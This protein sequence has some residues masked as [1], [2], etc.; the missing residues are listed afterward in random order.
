V[1]REPRWAVAHKYPAQE[2]LTTVLN[3][4]VQ[5]GRTGKLT[6]V[7]KLAPV[8]VGGTTVSNATLHNLFE[9]RRKGV[10]V[11]DTVIVRR[12]GDVIPEVVG[13]CRAR[14]GYVPNFRMPRSCPVCGSRGARA[15]AADHRCT[16]RPVLRRAAQAGHPA[17]CRRR[18]MEVEGLGDKLVDQ[19]VDGGLIRT[20]PELYRLGWPSWRRWTAWPR[21][22]RPTWLAGA[23][24]EQAD[25]AAALPVTRWASAMSARPRPRTW[26]ALRQP[27]PHHGRHAWSSCCR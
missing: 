15:R 16:R 26:R 18:A 10:R 24:Q 6:P 1:T 25:H 5:V 8:F 20:L 27:G 22:A 21:R 17:L 23:G 11:G 7:A 9:L 4:D 12:A 14:A 2:Q 3:I 19:L 13:R